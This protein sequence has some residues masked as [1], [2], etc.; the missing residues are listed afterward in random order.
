[1]PAKGS[2]KPDALSRRKKV[3]VSC[4]LEAE[5]RKRAAA[6]GM[7]EARWMRTVLEAAVGINKPPPRRIIPTG[8]EMLAALND[9]WRQL[10]KLGTNINQLARQANAGLVPLTRAE[11]TYITNQTQLALARLQAL[12]EGAK[13]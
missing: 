2:R 8:D 7:S 4:A 13:P 11:A 12:I 6:A 9:C 10:K 5:I 1:M 3:Q